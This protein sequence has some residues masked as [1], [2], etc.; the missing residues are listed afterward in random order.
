MPEIEFTVRVKLPPPV[1]NFQV[2]AG[3]DVT[4][5]LDS[6]KEEF[7]SAVAKSRP[8]FVVTPSDCVITDAA[9]VERKKCTVPWLM[10]IGFVR[11]LQPHGEYYATVLRQPADIDSVHPSRYATLSWH[12]NGK[13]YANGF[14][15]PD[16]IYQDEVIA[17]AKML[18]LPIKS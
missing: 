1:I 8:M 16:L 17:A 12:D 5:D 11:E 6:L 10:N 18:G 3:P 9:P 4:W 14:G 7:K 15:I 2:P 13:W